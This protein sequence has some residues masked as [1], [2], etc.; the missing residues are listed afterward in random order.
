LRHLSLVIAAT[1]AG[2]FAA[3][4][5]AAAETQTAEP[6]AALLPLDPQGRMQIS[7]SDRCP[8]C[9]MRVDRHPKFAC[10]IQLKDQ[11]TY[12]F[13][14]AGCMIKSWL[15]PEI[16][17]G[18]AAEQFKR[19]VCREYFSGQ[20]LDAREVIWVAGSDV[21]GPM[22]PAVVPLADASHLAAFRRRHGGRTTFRLSE[23]NDAKWEAI[24]GK[25]AARY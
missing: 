5:P 6:A 20:T 14:S 13:C 22:G 11:R 18:K 7:A 12:Y 1:A 3:K 15:H 19:A 24:S 25:P 17:L 9:A 8:V 4:S 21:L 16:F 10:A 2:L 23:L